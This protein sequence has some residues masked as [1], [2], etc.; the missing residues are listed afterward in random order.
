MVRDHDSVPNDLR[1]LRPHTGHGR[2]ALEQEL[3]ES[4]ATGRS[5]ERFFELRMAAGPTVHVQL[6][7]GGHRLVIVTWGCQKAE[8]VV[9]DVPAAVEVADRIAGMLYEVRRDVGVVDRD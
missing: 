9:A 8:A 5:W 1:I 2:A 6:T 3:T 7:S 4:L